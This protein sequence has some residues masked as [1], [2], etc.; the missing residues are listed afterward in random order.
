[1]LST[2]AG[3]RSNRGAQPGAAAM[4]KA[5]LAGAVAFIGHLFWFGRSAHGR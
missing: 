2:V 5:V 3:S 4:V 1:M